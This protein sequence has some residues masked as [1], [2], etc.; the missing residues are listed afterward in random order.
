[1]ACLAACHAPWQSRQYDFRPSDEELYTPNDSTDLTTRHREQT[2]TGTPFA[3]NALF[4]DV[5]ISRFARG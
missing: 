3:L 4:S 1:V 2:L 5:R